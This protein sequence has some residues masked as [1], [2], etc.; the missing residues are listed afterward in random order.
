MKC[1]TYKQTDLGH[2]GLRH[3]LI[4]ETVFFVVHCSPPNES[5]WLFPVNYKTLSSFNIL[6]HHGLGMQTAA[7]FKHKMLYDSI[8]TQYDSF[9]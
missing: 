5:Q 8:V 7:R 4:I 3:V 6:Y 1:T 2:L 9:V